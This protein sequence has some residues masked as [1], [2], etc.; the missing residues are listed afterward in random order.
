MRIGSPHA[1]RGHPP[2]AS[3]APAVPPLVAG[4][5]RGGRKRR[6]PLGFVRAAAYRIFW[7]AACPVLQPN[8]L[9]LAHDPNFLTCLLANNDR[10]VFSKL[11][12][13]ECSAV[14][15]APLAFC[16]SVLSIPSSTELSTRADKLA[17][18]TR[19]VQRMREAISN[20]DPVLDCGSNSSHRLRIAAIDSRHC[21]GVARDDDSSSSWWPAGQDEVGVGRG[22]DVCYLLS[23][24]AVLGSLGSL[25]CL[26]LE[27][28]RKTHSLP[29][30]K[31]W[32]F[33]SDRCWSYVRVVRQ[34]MRKPTIEPP[35]DEMKA[36]TA[37]AAQEWAHPMRQRGRLRI[38]VYGSCLPFLLEGYPRRLSQGQLRHD[39]LATTVFDGATER[40]VLVVERVV[41][42]AAASGALMSAREEHA[43]VISGVV[44]L[45]HEAALPESVVMELRA[46]QKR[47]QL[48][49]FR[50]L[51]INAAVSTLPPATLH[52]RS[53]LAPE[54]EL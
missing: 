43:A 32:G 37:A 24:D 26:G 20:L 29:S 33:L 10:G 22:G 15:A 23:Q 12:A 5:P 8:L 1:G 14:M 2:R 16:M 30:F 47:G 21:S 7:A 19:M 45:Q 52:S 13:D 27:G 28:Q 18:R 49:V 34:P 46:G 6:L 50:L 41:V 39:A 17:S 11:P 31:L 53:P 35:S 3:P 54:P 40:R 36:L 42:D 44:R 48:T 38:A 4:E 51:A 25:E 9:F